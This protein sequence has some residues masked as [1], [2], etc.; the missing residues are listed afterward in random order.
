[1]YCSRSLPFGLHAAPKIATGARKRQHYCRSGASGSGQHF[2][3]KVL[4]VRFTKDACNP[5]LQVGNEPRR[6][7]R[8]THH[9]LDHVE[10]DVQRVTGRSQSFGIERFASGNQFTRSTFTPVGNPGLRFSH[11][12]IQAGRSGLGPFGHQFP[13]ESHSGSGTFDRPYGIHFGTPKVL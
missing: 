5:G 1:M 7:P 11:F 4:P 13:T 9:P 8:A 10:A 12:A 6:R 3:I 2:A